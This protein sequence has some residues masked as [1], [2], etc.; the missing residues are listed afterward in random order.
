LNETNLP[1]NVYDLA[2]EKASSS[3]D[4]C[5]RV[6]VSF[7]Y[8]LPA[9]KNPGGWVLAVLGQWQAGGNFTA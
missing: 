9:A 2:T 1:Q 4:H 5:Y 3:F 8:Q 7:L 6:V